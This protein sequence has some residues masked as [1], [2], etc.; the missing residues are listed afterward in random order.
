MSLTR[1][2]YG[3]FQHAAAARLPAECHVGL[4]SS[5]KSI[6][7]SILDVDGKCLLTYTLPLEWSHQWLQ[8]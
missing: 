7:N 2:E 8:A 6:L 1:H 3:I 4:S 5:H